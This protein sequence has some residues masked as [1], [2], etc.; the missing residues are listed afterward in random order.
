MVPRLITSPRV[1]G[2]FPFMPFVSMI[3]C[4]I[5]PD[6]VSQNTPSQVQT[7]VLVEQPAEVVIHDECL[8][9]RELAKSHINALSRITCG[10]RLGLALGLCPETDNSSHKFIIRKTQRA[11]DIQI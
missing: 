8:V 7:L 1:D 2:I 9:T 4:V 3:S 5:T 11:R 6:V 10:L